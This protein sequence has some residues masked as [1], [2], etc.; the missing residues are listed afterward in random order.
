MSKRLGKQ[1]LLLPSRPSVLACAGVA[2]KKEGE[3]LCAWH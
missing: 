1:T 2:G 3:V